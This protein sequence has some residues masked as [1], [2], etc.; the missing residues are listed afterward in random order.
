MA[1]NQGE[2]AMSTDQST[3]SAQPPEAGSTGPLAL[4]VP[5]DGTATLTRLPEAGLPVQD[6]QQLNAIQE[7]V[8]GEFEALGDG[9]WLILLNAARHDLPLPVNT[10]ASLLARAL[11]LRPRDEL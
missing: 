4:V 1:P 2:R 6:R 5:P 8:G 11:G 3:A 10:R 9:R 7:A